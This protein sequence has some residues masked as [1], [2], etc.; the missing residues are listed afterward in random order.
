LEIQGATPDDLRPM[1]IWRGD[2]KSAPDALRAAACERWS[3]GC[4][5]RM[6]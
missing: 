3:A 5:L 6:M 1:S 2:M 4:G